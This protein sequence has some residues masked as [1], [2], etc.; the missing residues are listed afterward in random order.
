MKT[1]MIILSL[2]CGSIAFAG[3]GSGTMGGTSIII[4]DIASN[5]SEIIYQIDDK[6]GIVK[7]EYGKRENSTW[8]IEVFEM[9]KSEIANDLEVVQALAKSKSI[10]NWSEIVYIHSK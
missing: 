5:V 2:L 8:V 10:N 1:T 4:N 9:P 7:F 6:D 3:N